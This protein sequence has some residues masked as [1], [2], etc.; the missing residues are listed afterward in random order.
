MKINVYFCENKHDL[1]MHSNLYNNI[2]SAIYSFRKTLTLSEATTIE[3][4][5]FTTRYIL[6]CASISL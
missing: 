4:V 3:E 5:R 6:V 1:V 2:K